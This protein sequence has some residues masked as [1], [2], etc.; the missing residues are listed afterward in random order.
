MYSPVGKKLWLKCKD[1]L[2]CCI[3]CNICL[4]NYKLQLVNQ[5]DI[6][7]GKPTGTE[8]WKL[9]PNIPWLPS[10]HDVL[11]LC[12]LHETCL[13]RH[14]LMYTGAWKPNDAPL[15]EL[16]DGEGK[17]NLRQLQMQGNE[18]I[19]HRWVMTALQKDIY[20]TMAGWS[21]YLPWL[22]VCPTRCVASSNNSLNTVY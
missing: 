4:S 20:S 14:R 3:C 19:V 9:H 15:L 16:S 12:V 1:I 21:W 6:K 8:V 22:R 5:N 7:Y 11:A 18:K 13:C 17:L 2:L 10:G